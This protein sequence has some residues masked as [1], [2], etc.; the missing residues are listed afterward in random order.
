[1]PNADGWSRASF[2]IMATALCYRRSAAICATGPTSF[3]GRRFPRPIRRVG[4]A[5]CEPYGAARRLFR[6]LVVA[7]VL[8]T[9]K[10][11]EAAFPVSLVMPER[12]RP[13][14]PATSTVCHRRPL[15]LTAWVPQVKAGVRVRPTSRESDMGKRKA[16]IRVVNVPV[17]VVIRD[18]L[19]F[20]ETVGGW[21]LAR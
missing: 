14:E 20:N 16:E 2:D 11:T 13:S 8:P 3:S 15:I 18:A 6:A 19:R 4:R 7:A 9:E 5:R 17:N 12:S 1:M 21:T 10:A